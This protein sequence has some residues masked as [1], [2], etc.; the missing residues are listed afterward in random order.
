MVGF[1]GRMVC[2]GGR[3]LVLGIGYGTSY[4]LADLLSLVLQ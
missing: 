4:L 1:P 3:E 2:T